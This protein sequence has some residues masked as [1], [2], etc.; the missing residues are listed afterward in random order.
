MIHPSMIH[1]FHQIPGP[2]FLPYAE[3]GDPCTAADRSNNVRA[4]PEAVWCGVTEGVEGQARPTRGI[5]RPRR[6]DE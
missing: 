2:S 4:M 6:V 1:H 5:R 3:R